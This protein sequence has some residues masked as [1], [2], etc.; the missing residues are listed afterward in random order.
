MAFKLYTG[1]VKQIWYPKKASIAIAV[2][3]LMYAASGTI[4]LAD[5]TSGNHVG[6]SNKVWASSDA[7][8]DPTPVIVPLSPNVEWKVDIGT[9]TATAAMIQTYRDLKDEDEADVS[10]QSKNVLLMTK[11]I[12]T[13]YCIFI[14]NAMGE[15]VDVATT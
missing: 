2:G 8:T 10:A 11:F 1:R 5:S 4:L 6:V 3:D 7:T 13:S 14:V 15:H 12:N 9:G